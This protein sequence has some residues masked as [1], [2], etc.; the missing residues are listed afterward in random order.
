[1]NKAG[2]ASTLVAAILLA[3]AVIVEAQQGKVY[4]VGVLTIGTSD[5][6][7]IKGLRDGLKEAGYVEGKNLVFDT[8]TKDTYEELRP[9]ARRMS[10]KNL[11]SL[12]PLGARQR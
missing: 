3:V 5:N 10:K 12:S 6:P 4:Y 7:H 9:V 11:M 1:M 2:W 8:P